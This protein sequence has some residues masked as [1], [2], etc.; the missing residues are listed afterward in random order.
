MARDLITG[1]FNFEESKKEI[2]YLD[3]DQVIPSLENFYSMKESDILKM[4]RSI[5]A[6]GEIKQPL[7][8]KNLDNGTYEIIAGHKRRAGAMQL[9]NE[10]KNE[11]RNLPCIVEQ[12]NIDNELSL[13]LTNATQRELSAFEKM[14]QVEI[15]R[16]YLEKNEI[17]GNKREIISELMSL[18]KSEVGR[19]ENISRNLGDSLKEEFAAGTIATGTAN[20]IASMPREQQEEVEK[21]IQEHGSIK[22]GE[23]KA[24]KSGVD[25]KEEDKPLAG[26]MKV[27]DYPG[28]L[29]E[30]MQQ[31]K[32]ERER[33]KLIEIYFEH[34]DF[35]KEKILNIC[36]EA[37]KS[38][39][40]KAKEIQKFLAPNGY[41]SEGSSVIDYTFRGY[42]SGLRL[43]SLREKID[44][45]SYT[46]VQFL[47]YTEELFL[48]EIENLKRNK[49]SKSE[50]ISDSEFLHAIDVTW[51]KCL[52]DYELS[53]KNPEAIPRATLLKFRILKEAMDM[54]RSNYMAEKEAEDDTQF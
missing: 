2:I 8:V 50:S 20:E 9:V 42:A 21:I 49:V 53:L 14:K 41:S 28:L 23:V 38:N 26:Q 4:A 22:M 51:K 34:C 35:Y 43:G 44:T 45:Q 32:M 46:Y 15:L 24:I 27:E 6:V 25:D 5:E 48:E 52:R 37:N 12:E 33:K 7:L 30:E 36:L 54:Y 18:S 16:E 40:E 47:K 29:T 13:I 10:G 1:L 39:V 17:E 11:Y 3:I 19:L 31:E